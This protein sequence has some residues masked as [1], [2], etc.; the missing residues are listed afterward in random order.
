MR[1]SLLNIVTQ[2]YQMDAAIV[3]TC[4]GN[5]R[6]CRIK[7]PSQVTGSTSSP[8]TPVASAGLASSPFSTA[9]PANSLEYSDPSTSSGLTVITGNGNGTETDEIAS[10]SPL[11]QPGLMR[12]NS[13]SDDQHA[14][15]PGGINIPIHGGAPLYCVEENFEIVSLVGT[16][17]GDSKDGDC[18]LNIALADK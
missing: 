13:A 18:N 9:R 15:H 8:N 16:L 1:K 6:K 3:L 12:I 14:K 11:H 4:V 2:H 10:P 5:L 17:S 7:L